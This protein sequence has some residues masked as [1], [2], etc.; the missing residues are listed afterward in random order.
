M[1]QLAADVLSRLNV[2][3]VIDIVIVS[4]SIYWMLLLIRG[5]TAMTVLRGVAVLLIGAFVASRVFELRVVNWILRNSVAGLLIGLIIIFQPEIRRAL[6]RLGRT[7]LRSVFGR[8]E[9]RDV[10]DMVVRSALHLARR[11]IGALLVLERET[12]L[13]EVIDT[14]IPLDA[15]VSTEL[16][17]TIFVTSSPLHDGAVVIRGDRAVAAGCT[18]P[19]SEAPLP[20]EYG[21]RHRAALGIAERTDAVIVVVSEERGEV[22]IASNGR[23]APALDEAQLHRQLHRLFG[24]EPPVRAPED[25]PPPTATGG[26]ER[27]AS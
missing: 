3:A 23:M 22:S 15:Q 18:L 10:V 19:L 11:N 1:P 26:V 2:S 4:V 14:G 20:T 25:Q 6:E 9:N 13:Q 12:G 8:T 17:S 24:I 5:S 21:T 16:L 27:R 7:G